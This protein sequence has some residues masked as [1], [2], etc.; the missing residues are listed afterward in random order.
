V[1][2]DPRAIRKAYLARFGDFL[3]RPSG[4]M[5]CA[6]DRLRCDADRPAAGPG[7][8][9]LPF[10]ARKFLRGKR[11]NRGELQV[12]SDAR[13]TTRLTSPDPDP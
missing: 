3:R 2:V 9:Q 12:A 10:V 4:R 11:F 7:V 1:L 8:V 6:A 13:R 5:P